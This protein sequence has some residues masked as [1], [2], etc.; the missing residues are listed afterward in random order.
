[1]ACEAMTVEVI[2]ETNVMFNIENKCTWRFSNLISSN[3]ETMCYEHC[4]LA[5]V[6]NPA[7]NVFSSSNGGAQEHLENERNN[8]F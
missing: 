8:I 6:S 1:M 4:V 2:L 3:T 5:Q 7:Q